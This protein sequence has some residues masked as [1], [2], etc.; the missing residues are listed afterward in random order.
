MIAMQCHCG[1]QYFAKEADLKRGWG[2]SCSKHCAAVRRDFGKP[3][4]KRLDGLK[5]V[6]TAKKPL[7]NRVRAYTGKNFT[8]EEH[9]QACYDSEVGW[10]GHKDSF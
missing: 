6:K 9:L 10:D 2:L 1:N 4:A 8:Y 3:A 5:I 7:P